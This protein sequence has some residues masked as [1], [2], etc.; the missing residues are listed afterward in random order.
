MVDRL[1]RLGDDEPGNDEPY[2]R[3]MSPLGSDEWDIGRVGTRRELARRLVGRLDSYFRLYGVSPSEG[4]VSFRFVKWLSHQC[5]WSQS[6]P[7]KKSRKTTATKLIS[8]SSPQ[9]ISVLCQVSEDDLCADSE[10]F[11]GQNSSFQ[12]TELKSDV[13]RESRS[14]CTDSI[15]QCQQLMGE[16]IMD[17]RYIELDEWIAKVARDGD[18]LGQPALVGSASGDELVLALIQAVHDR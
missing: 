16:C 10:E 4:T 6:Q 9:K 5:V 18:R 11:E 12:L 1:G 13:T 2:R 17:Q 3:L 14:V 15:G 8:P 7:T